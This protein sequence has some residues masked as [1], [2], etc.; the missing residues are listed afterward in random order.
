MLD[1][2]GFPDKWTDYNSLLLNSTTFFENIM[3]LY[4]FGVKDDINQFYK[5][6][7]RYVLLYLFF[8]C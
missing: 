4:S 7:D 3:A 1:L 2:V 5:A 8:K 6:P